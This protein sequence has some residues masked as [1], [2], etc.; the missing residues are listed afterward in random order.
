MIRAVLFDLEGTL[1][2]S[3]ERQTAIVKE[4]FKRAS[5]DLQVDV[6]SIYHLRSKPEF[7]TSENFI[8]LVYALHKRLPATTQSLENV[9]EEG[10]VKQAHI[11]YKRLRRENAFEEKSELIPKAKEALDYFKKKGVKTAIVTNA[12]KKLSRKLL[13]R[14]SLEPTLLIT[15]EECGCEKPDPKM[16]EWSL[17]ALKVKPEDA[18][19]IEDSV[20][21]IK[22]AKMLGMKTI[23][24]LTGNSKKE[25]MDA[26][27]PDAV[28]ENVA[29]IVKWFQ[30][31]VI[32][33][34]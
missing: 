31:K 23:G 34:I 18:L 8:A 25:E 21:G 12:N 19:V 29:Q 32:P 20:A 14:F 24:V 3:L 5:V 26:A 22:A 6:K 9:K 4:A 13:E 7:H 11:E 33:W 2:T 27:K 30:N 17:N 16:F 15:E 1:V 28:L 10:L